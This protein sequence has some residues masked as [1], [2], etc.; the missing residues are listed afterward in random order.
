MMM[1]GE[2]KTQKARWEM[3]GTR[4]KLIMKH[5]HT[6]ACDSLSGKVSANTSARGM[7]TSGK[8]N[9]FADEIFILHH[10]HLPTW[11]TQEKWIKALPANVKNSEDFPN[12]NS[13][14]DAPMLTWEVKSFF[15]CERE[16]ER[17]RAKTEKLTEE[18]FLFPK[19]ATQARD[20]YIAWRRNFLR[21][22]SV[23]VQFVIE[24]GHPLKARR[25]FVGSRFGYCVELN[26]LRQPHRRTKFIC[27]A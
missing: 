9:Q 2:C 16:R 13:A 11:A 18:F 22:S 6:H 25:R 20:F 5:R 3:S 17:E 19:K 7:R 12:N 27:A 1:F 24:T 23:D 8:T 10:H 4:G 21:S 15:R 26:S 14:R